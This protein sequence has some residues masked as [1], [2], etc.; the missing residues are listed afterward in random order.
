MNL[1]AEMIPSQKLFHSV[2]DIEAAYLK[3][4]FENDET[5]CARTPP[6]YRHTIRGVPVVWRLK[7]PLHGEA[8]AGRIWNRTLVRQ[9]RDRQ[10]FNQ[11]EFDPCYFRLVHDNGERVDILM[12][13]DDG[14]V[15]TNSK[16]ATDEALTVLHQKF[17]LSR[18]D[19][20]F[21]LGNNLA[22]A[23]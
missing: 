16:K 20:Q 3:G 17:T 6:G 7:I 18:K 13:V 21:F 12:Y 19:A 2:F 23:G 22:V 15:V 9:L 11:S 14:Y 5:V 1:K 8:D 4:E 10:H